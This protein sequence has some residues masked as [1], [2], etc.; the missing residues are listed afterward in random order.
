MNALNMPFTD[1]GKLNELQF[2]LS[3]AELLGKIQSQVTSGAISC[4]TLECSG[5]TGEIRPISL[6]FVKSL[7]QTRVAERINYINAEIVV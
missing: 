4:I 3:L 6:A 2:A 5:I 7:L 1:L